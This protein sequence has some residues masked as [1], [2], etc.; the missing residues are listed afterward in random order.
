MSRESHIA[1]PDYARPVAGTDRRP[2]IMRWVAPALTGLL[3]A[4]AVL[5]VSLV[6]AV[7]SLL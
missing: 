6:A 7:A 4:A 2:P 3:V 5:L 1:P